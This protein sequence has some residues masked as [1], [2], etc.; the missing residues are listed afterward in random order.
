[1]E[2]NSFRQHISQQFNAEL[3]DVRNRVLEMGGFVEKQVADA[4]QSLVDGDIE[5]AE[6]V[7]TN[8][9]KVNA[10]EVEID[11]ECAQILALRQPAASDLRLIVAVI[12]TITD[13]ERMG[14]QAEKVARMALRLAELERPKN[15]YH[16]VQSL[17]QRANELLHDTLD[18]FARM[19]HAAAVKVAQ[20]DLKVDHEYESIIRQRI[21]FMMEDPRSIARSLDVMWAARALERIGDH[22]RNICEYVIYLVK[23]KDV[24]HISLEQMEKEVLGE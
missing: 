1:M 23:G 18:V 19:D 8:D 6:K 14:D 2:E 10:M 11:E 13:L 4:I 21:T 17:G 24:R 22:A 20:H 16:E 5:L 3:E 12:K 9:Y 15:Q 7:I